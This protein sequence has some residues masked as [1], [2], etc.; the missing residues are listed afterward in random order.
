MSPS[1]WTRPGS[2]D[3]IGSASSEAWFNAIDAGGRFSWITVLGILVFGVGLIGV[4]PR[5]IRV[6][7]RRFRLG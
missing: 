1:N 4:L 7:R 5:A 2:A 3:Q 6:A